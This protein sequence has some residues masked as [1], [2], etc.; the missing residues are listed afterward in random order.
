[1]KPRAGSMPTWVDKII[2]LLQSRFEVS[3]S[4]IL[5]GYKSEERVQDIVSILPFHSRLSNLLFVYQLPYEVRK[6]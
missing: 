4:R 3:Q 5:L 2:Q 6:A 1:M